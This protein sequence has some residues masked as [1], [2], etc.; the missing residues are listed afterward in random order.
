M[1]ADNPVLSRVTASFCDKS[2]FFWRRRGKNQ[3]NKNVKKMIIRQPL[4]MPHQTISGKLRKPRNRFGESDSMGGHIRAVNV[5]DHWYNPSW[6]LLTS[7]G[8]MKNQNN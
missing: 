7:S 1:V 5:T 8:P 2:N 4:K 6:K 3:Q